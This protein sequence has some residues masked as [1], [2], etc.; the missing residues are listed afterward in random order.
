MTRAHDCDSHKSRD[1]HARYLLYGHL[2]GV[3]YLATNNLGE[4]L[5]SLGQDK[6]MMI[7]DDD[8]DNDDIDDVKVVK[9]WRHAPP[10]A[11]PSGLNNNNSLPL[12]QPVR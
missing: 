4:L 7:I 2:G 9:V 8:D 12:L 3:L 1:C 6:V 5:V 10:S 11:P